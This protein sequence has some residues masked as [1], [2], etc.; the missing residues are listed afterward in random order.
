M[1]RKMTNLSGLA[2]DGLARENQSK[3]K[4]ESPDRDVLESTASL[5]PKSATGRTRWGRTVH[6]QPLHIRIE[7]HALI[8]VTRCG[9]PLVLPKV[10]LRMAIGKGH[11]RA[12]PMKIARKVNQPPIRRMLGVKCWVNDEC[13]VTD[14][15]RSFVRKDKR[16]RRGRTINTPQLPIGLPSLNRPV[17][18]HIVVHRHA[19]DPII[20]LP[21]QHDL[22][23]ISRTLP[24]FVAFDVFPQQTLVQIPAVGS[25]RRA[26]RHPTRYPS[27][28]DLP[29]RHH[30]NSIRRQVVAL[31]VR[32]KR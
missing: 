30:P 5:A 32:V 16:V 19:T 13:S 18:T 10:N 31:V 6:I 9:C 4:P 20:L 11:A 22:A 27:L 21:V 12:G 29:N 28:A 24:E 8:R 2:S 1:L 7:S 14:R 26:R 17:R 25:V 3:T 15:F 23:G